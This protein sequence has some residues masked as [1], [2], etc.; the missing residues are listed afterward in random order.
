MALGLDFHSHGKGLPIMK[1]QRSTDQKGRQTVSRRS[2][3]QA[4]ALAAGATLGFPAIVR[5]QGKPQ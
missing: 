1:T 3:L 4:S 5:G 2:F